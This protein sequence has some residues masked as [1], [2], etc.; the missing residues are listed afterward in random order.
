MEDISRNDD[1]HVGYCVYI[2]YVVVS[3]VA[4]NCLHIL[5]KADR[6]KLQPV[7]IGFEDLSLLLTLGYLCP[8][9]NLRTESESPAV[10][11]PP[12]VPRGARIEAS[13]PEV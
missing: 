1:V 12:C 8:K 4:Q 11:K 2:K 3:H 9:L 7:G 6:P 10:H 13:F 5:D